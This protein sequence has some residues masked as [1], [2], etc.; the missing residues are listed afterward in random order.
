MRRFH[1][2]ARYRVPSGIPYLTELANAC[3]RC[4]R[5]LPGGYGLIELDTVI[6][7]TLAKDMPH[8]VYGVR[9]I[10][11]HVSEVRPTGRRAT[12]RQRPDLRGAA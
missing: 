11:L 5:E 10:A 7:P 4:V 8:A 12:G 2:G 3:G 1:A 9:R 6:P